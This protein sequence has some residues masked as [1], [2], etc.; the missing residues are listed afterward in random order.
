MKSGFSPADSG[1]NDAARGLPRLVNG[2]G[3]GSQLRKE[4]VV[5]IGVGTLILLVILILLLT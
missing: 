3:R 5:Y 2:D 4:R 1:R